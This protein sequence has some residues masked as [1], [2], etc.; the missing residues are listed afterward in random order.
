VTWHSA[1]TRE[2]DNPDGG[3]VLVIR[4][5]FSNHVMLKG[6]DEISDDVAAAI[7]SVEQTARGGLKIKFHDKS[8]ALK[9]LAQYRGML[10]TDSGGTTVSVRNNVNVYA[11]VDRPPKESF[12]DF[13]ER[14]QRELGQPVRQL[15]TGVAAAAQSV[16]GSDQG[17]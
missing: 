5:I 10:A 17:K 8:W 7:S 4:H 16:N 3:D 2:E 13:T 15:E 14:R 1:L 11:P 12:E 6:S 9:L